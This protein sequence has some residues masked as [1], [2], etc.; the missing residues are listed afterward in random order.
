M[1]MNKRLIG[2][3]VFKSPEENTEGCNSNYF[4]SVG[5]CGKSNRE[6]KR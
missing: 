4:I 1:G 2:G 3:I 5:N 6:P